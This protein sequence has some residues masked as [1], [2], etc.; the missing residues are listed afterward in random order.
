MKKLLSLL[1]MLVLVIS[2]ASCS[3]LPEDI[4]AK[5][6]DVKNS[7]FGGEQ[8]DNPPDDGP[9]VHS[10]EVVESTPA[11]CT[12][13]GVVKS[14]CSCG[15]AGEEVLTA[16]GHDMQ[17]NGGIDVSCTRNGMAYFK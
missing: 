10:F 5:L 15:E 6:E 17:P 13:D 3:M 7:I 8:P 4:Q 9:H 2:L 1:L 16:T 14:A 12:E 11:S